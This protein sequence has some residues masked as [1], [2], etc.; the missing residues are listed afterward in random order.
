MS[1]VAPSPADKAPWHLWAIGIVGLLWNCIGAL[2]YTMT[3]TRNEAYLKAVTPEQL[4]Y[5][6]S[7]PAW[8]V[9]AWALGVWGGVAGMLLLLL[10]KRAAVPVLLVSL[11]GATLIFVHNFVLSEGAEVMGNSAAGFAGMIIMIALGLYWYARVMRRR[12]VLH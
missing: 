3:Q 2:D 8:A 10:R 12:G 11:V 4:A 6:D 7:V 1:D 5:F 9:A